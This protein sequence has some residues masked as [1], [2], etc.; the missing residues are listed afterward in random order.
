MNAFSLTLRDLTRTLGD[1]DLQPALVD[2][3]HSA[4]G[5]IEQDL[6]ARG[7]PATATVRRRGGDVSIDV[8]GPDLWDREHG[9]F[10]RE[11]EGNLDAMLA[12]RR[13]P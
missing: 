3:A 12:D 5:E 11:A 8:T 13:R 4:A 9:G 7:Q 10:N 2:R 1:I 6:A